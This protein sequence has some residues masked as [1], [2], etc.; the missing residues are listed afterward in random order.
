MSL[1]RDTEQTTLA[2]LLFL[3]FAVL[4]SV[5][6]L[7]AHLF[8]HLSLGCSCV[9]CLC[10]FSNKISTTL[11]RERK[12]FQEK[13]ESQLTEM[14][15]KLAKLLLAEAN[16][17]EAASTAAVASSAATAVAI[18]HSPDAASTAVANAA[19]SAAASAAG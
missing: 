12:N 6:L 13:I 10:Q 19:D 9:P 8:V 11:A 17:Q 16:P 4:G 3:V 7:S 1:L 14:E 5:V 2:L 15:T 18:A